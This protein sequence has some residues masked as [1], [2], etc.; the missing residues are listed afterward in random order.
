MDNLGL[1]RNAYVG[2]AHVTFSAATTADRIVDAA[3]SREYV[4]GFFHSG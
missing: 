4:D 3:V 1:R 2:N